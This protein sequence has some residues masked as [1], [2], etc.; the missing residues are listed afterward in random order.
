MLKFEK[1]TNIKDFTINMT[2]FDLVEDII[3]KIQDKTGL[4]VESIHLDM[5][6][7]PLD[8]KCTIFE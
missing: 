7:Q 2:M 1:D 8:S 6:N 5:Y 4:P 3:F